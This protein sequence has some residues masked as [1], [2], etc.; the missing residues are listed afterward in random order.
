MILAI[1]VNRDGRSGDP[2]VTSVLP[3]EILATVRDR[4]SYAVVVMTL[5]GG[6]LDSQEFRIIIIDD[7]DDGY[8]WMLVSGRMAIP[9]WNTGVF[10]GVEHTE[11]AA[12]SAGVQRAVELSTRVSEPS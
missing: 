2:W 1:N 10:R 11:D 7:C 5:T 9:D 3:P 8:G 12:V 4:P 6:M